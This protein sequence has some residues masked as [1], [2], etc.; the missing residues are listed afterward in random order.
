MCNLTALIMQ[1][2]TTNYSK[3]WMNLCDV[4]FIDANSVY[5]FVVPLHYLLYRLR[6]PKYRPRIP[7]KRVGGRVTA[8]AQFML[9]LGLSAKTRC[10]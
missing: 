9:R 10:L 4:L 3:Y 7:K 6:S 2:V 8:A 5:Y 1:S